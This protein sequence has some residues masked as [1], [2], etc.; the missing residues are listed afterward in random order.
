VLVSNSSNTSP[1]TGH[2]FNLHAGTNFTV[3]T[4][5]L[6]PDNQAL[7]M[8]A[9][10]EPF[11]LATNPATISLAYGTGTGTGVFS[12][13][14][15]P[16]Q[17]RTAPYIFSV[18]VAESYG[19]LT[20]ANDI[21]FR[22]NVNSATGILPITR[23]EVNSI[24]PNPNSGTFTVE[25]NALS[26]GNADLVIT[27][28]LGQQVHAAKNIR[29]NEGVNAIVVNHVSLPK[30]NYMIRIV[31]DGKNIGVRNFEVNY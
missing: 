3:T 6:D 22:L 11:L 17:L 8:D 28:M 9:K 19:L 16:S 21:T 29:L 10:G 20:F 1:F 7:V 13:S 15:L 12:W 18:R 2:V 23:D 27:N 4:T 5:V 31:K 30:G 25:I 26:G 14:P 24:Y